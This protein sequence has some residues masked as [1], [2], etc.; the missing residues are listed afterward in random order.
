MMNFGLIL[1]KTVRVMHYQLEQVTQSGFNHQE[2]Y[3]DCFL[4]C[5]FSHTK[6]IKRAE[7]F[8]S[9]FWTLQSSRQGL[10]LMILQVVPTQVQHC[11]LGGAGLQS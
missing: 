3:T 11:K 5:S 4:G 8:Q 10:P 1:L 6:V 2:N 7:N 9:A